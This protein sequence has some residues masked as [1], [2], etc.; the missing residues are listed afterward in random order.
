MKNKRQLKLMLFSLCLLCGITA[1]S[2]EK[3]EEDW[4]I[5]PINLYV[6]VQDA[7][8]TDL[9]DPNKPDNIT[10]KGIKAIYNNK[11]YNV[12]NTV[13][14][15]YNA[16]MNGLQL[17]KM[18]GRYALKFGEFKGEIDYHSETVIIDWND[19]TKDTFSFDSEFTWKNKKP[20]MKTTFFLNGEE[21]KETFY[22]IVK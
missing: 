13:S 1:C 18:D 16:T 17:V 22:T 4:D 9:L 11:E 8:G 5:N 7:G 2:N 15:Y 19:G 12:K 21:I 10:N 14:R 6:F 3:I 20:N